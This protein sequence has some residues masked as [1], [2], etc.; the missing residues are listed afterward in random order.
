MSALAEEHVPS[1]VARHPLIQLQRSVVKR[2]AFGS[3]V[4]RS[5]N[6]RVTA[7][8]S[9]P[10]VVLIEKSDLANTIFFAE[11]IGSSEPVHARTNDYDIVAGAQIVTPP[12]SVFTEQLHGSIP[13]KVQ[14]LQAEGLEMKLVPSV[15][16]GL[17]HRFGIFPA[18]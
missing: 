7:T 15:N 6:R 18:D 13:Q 5:Q 11:I 12:H 14:R 3:P 2:N 8:G 16:D 10:Q 17:P 4:I 9:G 1:E